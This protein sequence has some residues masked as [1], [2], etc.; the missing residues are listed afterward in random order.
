MPARAGAEYLEGLRRRPRELW[1]AGQRVEDPTEHSVFA[2]ITRSIGALYDLQHY[3]DLREEM[4]YPSPTS[5]ERV[6]LSFLI[7]KTQE[8][9]VRIRRMMKRWADFSGEFMG[10]TLDYLNRALVGFASAAA[11]F[12]VSD[13]RF[14]ENVLRY[15]EYAR[16][17]DLCLTHTL[18]H[19]QVNRSVGPSQQADPYLAARIVKENTRGIVLRGARMLATLPVA[20]E[21]L[22]FPSTLLRAGMED[23]PYAFAVAVPCDAPGL[24]FQCRESFWYG[25]PTSDHLLSARFEEMDAV[26]I[27][28][29]V[30]VPWERVFLLRDVERCNQAFAETGA[31][32]FMAHQM[33]TKNVAKT[34]FILGVAS[35]AVETIAIEPYQHV[36][37][38]IA[39]IIIVLQAMRAFLR[40]SEVEAQPNRWGALV[41][42]WPPLNAARNLYVRTYPRLVEILQQLGASGFM[43][44]PTRGDLEGPMAP[45]I[46]RYCQ[47]AR[48]EATDRVRLF[49][50]AWDIALSAVGGRQVLYECFF[51]DPVRMASA[52]FQTYDRRPYMER[53]RAFLEEAERFA[54]E[55]PEESRTVN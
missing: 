20:D 42:A 49:R 28:K 1:Y 21:L 7:P 23:A 6:G 16:E 11:Y 12:A 54:P 17:N 24:R 13:S 30:F 51:C 53:V 15:Y 52:M 35:L 34:K 33:V 9:L 37:K 45:L 31:V 32:A 2:R 5:G 14:A 27:F 18:I 46:R 19:P 26:V 29:D 8:D 36:H 38:K 4:T 50:L 55:P 43:A 41:P 44:I 48:A 25:R 40:T 22:L 3:P 39:E 47:A 10:R